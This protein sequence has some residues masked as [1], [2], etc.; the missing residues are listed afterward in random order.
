MLLLNKKLHAL[1]GDDD[2]EKV[3]S[4]KKKL[5]K[6][7]SDRIDGVLLK[8]SKL[9]E[10]L[11]KTESDKRLSEEKLSGLDRSKRLFRT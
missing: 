7:L 9:N 11:N 4:E 8:Y 6:A 5:E 3:Y 10:K 2:Y 1:I